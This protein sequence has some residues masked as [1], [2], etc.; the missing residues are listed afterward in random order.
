MVAPMVILASIFILIP[1]I[2]T[3]IGSFFSIPFTGGEWK[4]VGFDNFTRVF[5]TTQIL[6]SILNTI[7]YSVLTII[8]SLVIGLALALGAESL[9]RGKAL[10][11]T[12]LFLPMTANLVAMAVVFAYI[13]DYRIGILNSL[14]GS[15]GV[16][17]I[18][19]LGETNTSLLTVALVGIWRTSSFTMMIF[20]AGLATIPGTMNEAAR[21]DGISGLTKVFRITLPAMKPSVVFATVMAVLQSVQA[22]DTVRVMTDGGPQ[23]SSEVIQTMAWRMGFEYFDLGTAS[24][25]SFIMIAVLIA[26]GLWQRKVLGGRNE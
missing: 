9:T 18:N 7:I 22:F 11:R 26:V 1:A 16:S 5:S 24:A 3:F 20:F 15:V 12:L 4:F 17:P 2:L 19:W 8:P 23:Y 25:L 13:F 14:L 6:K 21:M 10:V